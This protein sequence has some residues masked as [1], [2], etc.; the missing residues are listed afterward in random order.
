[1]GLAR[2][3]HLNL[4]V[5]LLPAVVLVRAE[6]L[7]HPIYKKVVR[8]GST[9]HRYPCVLMHNAVRN[10]AGCYTWPCPCH[11][12]A[13]DVHAIRRGEGTLLRRGGTGVATRAAYRRPRRATAGTTAA[14]DTSQLIWPAL[15]LP[16]LASETDA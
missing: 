3:A 6:T 9:K 10:G 7:A 12:H 14:A 1:M 11:R 2:R 16:C 8:H 4:R 15:R 13:A 5:L